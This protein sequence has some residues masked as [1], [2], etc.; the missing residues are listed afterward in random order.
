LFSADRARAQG[1]QIKSR[2]PPDAKLVK[3]DD[4]TVDFVLSKPNSTLIYEFDTWYMFSK[5]WAEANDAVNPQPANATALRPFA[6]KAN[7][8]GPFILVSH[9]PG[10]KTVFR[11]N[12][13][14]WGKAE[15][16]LT[17]VVFTTIASD[18]ERVAALLS[19]QVDWIDP[20]PVEAMDRVAKDPNVQLM[21]APELRTI[22]LMMDSFRDELKYATIREA[23][24]FKDRRVRQAVY[25]AID[26]G[27]IRDQVMSG[28]AQPTPLLISPLL[29]ARPVDFA[30]YPYDPVAARQLL[31]AAGYPDGFGVS[32]DC[33]NDRYVNDAQIC[34]EISQ[35]LKNIGI[36]VELKIMPKAVFFEKVGPAGG[37]DTSLYLF[38]WT[39]PSLD[40]W[41]VLTN[42]ASCRDK[43]PAGRAVNLR[44]YCSPAV[45]RVSEEIRVETDSDRRDRL[46]AEAFRVIHDDAGIIPLHQ[47]MLGWGVS[48]TISVRQR[49]DNQFFFNWVRKQ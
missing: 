12:T 33:P 49:A 15:H 14:W 24:P 29:Y 25:Q 40:S 44:G 10:I 34:T 38:G 17:G 9:E 11:P 22:M 6:L 2:L 23:N 20:V 30:R 31:A 1:S 39:P 18:T 43:T 3:V 45:D 35:M 41:N 5:T 7:G 42:L 32:M 37:Y 27:R 4:Y 19:G 21:A 26:T 47:Q 46:I 48:R 36:A 8:T 28:M 13:E 16:N